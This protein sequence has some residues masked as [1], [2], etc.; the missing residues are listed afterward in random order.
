MTPSILLYLSVPSPEALNVVSELLWTRVKLIA[1]V[2]SEKSRK[3]LSA[4]PS[5]VSLPARPRIMSLPPPPEMMSLPLLPV[6]VSLKLVPMTPSM[7]LYESV[8]SPGAV[9][10]V[11]ELL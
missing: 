7:F 2:A 4:P 3:S 10:V 1:P 9:N 8:P 11:S 6:S 5:I